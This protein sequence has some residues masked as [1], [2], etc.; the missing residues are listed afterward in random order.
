MKSFRYRCKRLTSVTDYS[1]KSWGAIEVPL[2]TTHTYVHSH[3]PCRHCRRYSLAR[4][5]AAVC[6]SVDDRVERN[7]WAQLC[8]SCGCLGLGLLLWV[9]HKGGVTQGH[10]YI[11]NPQHGLQMNCRCGC[12][13]GSLALTSELAKS[14]GHPVTAICPLLPICGVH[15]GFWVVPAPSL[16]PHRVQPLA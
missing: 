14:P 15:S 8:L 7:P 13:R 6:G 10:I 1:G 11:R 9:L 2:R 16:Y 3:T 12:W 5:F 4:E